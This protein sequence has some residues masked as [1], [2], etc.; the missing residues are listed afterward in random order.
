VPGGPS[1]ACEVRFSG[2]FW[3]PCA[4]DW[5]ARAKVGLQKPRS[6]NRRSEVRI[7]SGARHESADREPFEGLRCSYGR[8]AAKNLQG[9]PVETAAS[10]TTVTRP[11]P[12]RWPRPGQAL[13]RTCSWTTSLRR[14]SP[15]E[16]TA[17]DSRS[18]YDAFISVAIPAGG[19][20]PARR[21]SRPRRRPRST[22]VALGWRLAPSTTGRDTI[23]DLSSGW[24]STRS[25]A[26]P[27]WAPGLACPLLKRPR[28][29]SPSG[30]SRAGRDTRRR[31]GPRRF[32]A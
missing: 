24:A 29:R 25:R 10:S 18:D 8:G 9:R 21:A 22:A 5:L 32:A 16:P 14:A 19:L 1:Q 30:G 17:F 4:P 28:R 31:S 7:L 12:P 6:T 15:V 11:T 3:R 13:S 2:E 20:S 27:R 23:N 26:R